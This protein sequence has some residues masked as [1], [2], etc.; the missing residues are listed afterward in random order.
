MGS[1]DSIISV[2]DIRHSP[3]KFDA[4]P[5]IDVLA[6]KIKAAAKHSANFETYIN[7]QKLGGKGPIMANAMAGRGVRA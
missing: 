3:T 1:V 6:D 4:I 5:S 7:L 2:V